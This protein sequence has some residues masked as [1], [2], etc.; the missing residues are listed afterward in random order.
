MDELVSVIMP[1]F[2]VEAY[3]EKSVLSVCKQIYRPIEIVLVDDGTPDNSIEKAIRV[4]EA[5]GTGG[6]SYKVVRQEN[7]GVSKARNS[8][9]STA[10]GRWIVC[11]DPDDILDKSFVSSLVKI[12]HKNRTQV[13]A[14][15]Y[16]KIVKQ[17]VA[18]TERKGSVQGKEKLLTRNIA[19][20]EFLM[21][22]LRLICPAVL[23]EKD[24]LEKNRLSYSVNVRFSED[25]L[26]LWKLLMSTEQISYITEPLYLYLKRPNSTMSS[27]TIE[28]VLTGYEGI[29]QYSREIQGEANVPRE[30]KEYLL[31][32]WVLSVVRSSSMMLTYEE[33]ISLL[34]RMNYTVAMKRLKGFPDFRVFVLSEI[35][36]RNTKL[37]YQ[38]VHYAGS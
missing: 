13:S 30:I 34:T 9:I 10:S 14:A 38:L 1:V 22:R 35:L 37:F 36:K 11:V 2:Q 26:Y 24:Y 18:M 12:N 3:I 21:R 6:L 4:I 28:K 23:I 27:S 31:P 29:E 33:W 19:L 5:V 17:D 15:N 25:L 16:V 7:G 32:R 8:G 20:H